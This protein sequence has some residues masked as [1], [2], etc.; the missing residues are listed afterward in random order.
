M[1]TDNV[2]EPADGTET[3]EENSFTRRG[4]VKVAS[5]A[6]GAA[7]AVAIGYPIY[8]YLDAPVQQ[9]I[10]DAKNNTI[11]L[12]DADKLPAGSTLMFMF[13]SAP[14]ML[15][16]FD[17]GTWVALS[18]VCTHLGCTLSYTSPSPLIICP[19]HGGQYD[20]HTGKNVGGPPPR[21]LTKF[22]VQAEPGQVVVTQ[23]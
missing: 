5:V 9:A 20:P 13:K 14:A 16:H 6:V 3:E 21:P 1:N 2:I 22:D 17:D 4:F 19:C 23:P 7:Y 18:A 10:R 15:I 11:T 8:K 12:K